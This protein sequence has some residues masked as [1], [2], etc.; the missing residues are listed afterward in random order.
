MVQSEENGRRFPRNHQFG[1]D[2]AETPKNNPKRQKN[3]T[4][5]SQEFPKKKKFFFLFW[6]I[7]KKKLCLQKKIVFFLI[8]EIYQKK[9]LFFAKEKGIFLDIW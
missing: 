6:K 7:T 2:D 1:G 4:L 9:N 3:G 8:L 5:K